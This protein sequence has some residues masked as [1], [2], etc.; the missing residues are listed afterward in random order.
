MRAEF[1]GGAPGVA[2]GLGG[3]GELQA[4]YGVAKGGGRR[5]RGLAFG[6]WEPDQ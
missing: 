2:G 1:S 4:E 6:D 5:E 3:G